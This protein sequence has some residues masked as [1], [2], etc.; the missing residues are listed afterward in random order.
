MSRYDDPR[1]TTARFESKCHKMA[2]C[3]KCGKEIDYLRDFSPVWQEFKAFIGK[4]GSLDFETAGNECPMDSR[5]DEYVCPECQE[6]L[7]IDYQQAENFLKGV[8]YADTMER[9][10]G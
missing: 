6:V 8:N 5:D 7:F 2:K 10:K 4:N 1:W 3:P 9:I